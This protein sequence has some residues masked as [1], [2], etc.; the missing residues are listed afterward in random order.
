M[1]YPSLF[2]KKNIQR[3][4]CASPLLFCSWS[5][6]AQ[7]TIVVDSAKKLDKRVF[8]LGEVVVTGEKEKEINSTVGAEKLENFYRT[9][10]AKALNMLPGINLSAVG[11][12]N[13]AMV[14][15]RGFDLR[16]VPL[17]IDGIPVYVPYDGY[18]DLA[19]FTTFDLSEVNVSKGYTSVIYGPNAMGG[20]INLVSR[21][22][23]NTFE[24]N[25]ATG[26]MTGG[27]RTN[28]NIGSNLGKFYVQ[29][30]ASRI[31]RD[32]F[33]LAKDFE[34]TKNEDGGKRDNSNSEDTKYSVKIGFTP[35]GRSEY[36]LS[37]MYQHG[38]KGT[39]VYTGN[40][41]LNSQL[42]S[43]RYWQWPYWDKQSL[44]FISN[45]RLDSTQ[46]IKTRLYYDVFRN[47]LNS[48]D[49]ATYTTIS[50]PYAFK[51]YYDDYTF[52]GI[53]EYGKSLFKGKDIVKATLQYKQDVHRE[54]NEAEP[55]R[56][57]ADQTLTAGVENELKITRKLLLLTGFSYNYRESLQAM[58]YNS[59]TKA[60]TDFDKN[61]ND[62]YNIQG[63]LV[64][65]LNGFNAV[66][67]SI[68]RKTRFATV[69]DRYSYRL[70]TAIPNPNLAS[71]YTTNYEL[72]YKGNPIQK[73]N[74]QGALFYSHIENTIFS[75]S[76]VAYDA[77][78]KAWQSQLQNVGQ[79]E[80]IG[81]EVGAEYPVV[82]SVKVGANY[83]YIER[84][85]LTNPNIYFTDVPNHKVF[86]FVQYQP[87]EW[88]Y[89]QVNSE[90]N[91]KRYSTSY[92][93]STGEFAVLN[94]KAAFKIW[95]YF[96][97]ESGVNNILD[98]HYSLTEG[99]PEMGRNVFANLVYKF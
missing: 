40:D 42:K 5:A 98:K 41:P 78:R 36:A 92:G 6:I 89:L 67:L 24:L 1:F 99:Y 47:L 69:K 74:V 50:K 60:I 31:S 23:T 73:L 86:G 95:R 37:Y 10:A 53:A 21:R 20:A 62:A 38:K 97:V 26:W 25:G 28:V 8:E 80:Y 15:V 13:E 66:N 32:Y 54:N 81:A 93:S 52:G 57:M 17:L 65:H 75:V 9:D 22:P 88:V 85:N 96:S 59:T 71:E 68:A 58:N 19:R 82:K 83:T 33:Y 49:D 4:K 61:N 11:A 56:T 63:G 35:K 51:S 3:L 7:D 76:N 12:R 70:G 18:V 90:Y 64:Y 79:S 45:T 29:A 46:Y 30:G 94:A 43:P 16:Q 77:S 34:P 2:I 39:P 91:S 87:N 48:Y 27:Y 72:G 14:Y 44:Y 55:V 84:H